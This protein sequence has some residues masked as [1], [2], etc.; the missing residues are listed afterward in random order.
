[1]DCNEEKS[2]EC[3]SYALTISCQA[4]ENSSTAEQF[5]LL[6][7]KILF[8]FISKQFKVISIHFEQFQLQTVV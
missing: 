4:K 3:F 6:I 7:L 8:P 2:R 1:M 5:L